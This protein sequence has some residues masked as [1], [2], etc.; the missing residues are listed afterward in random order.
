[1]VEHKM[2]EKCPRKP[3]TVSTVPSLP[4]QGMAA[5]SGLP[6]LT[7]TMIPSAYAALCAR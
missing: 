1:M 6:F 5:V 4:A 7:G 2:M 3:R